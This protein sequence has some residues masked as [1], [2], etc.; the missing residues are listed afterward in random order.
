MNAKILVFV[1]FIEGII[2]LFLYNLHDCVFKRRVTNY[3]KRRHTLLH[4]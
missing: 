2:Y 4:Q 3:G 1:V